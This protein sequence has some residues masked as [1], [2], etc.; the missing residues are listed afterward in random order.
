MTLPGI[1]RRAV[2]AINRLWATLESDKRT[3]YIPSVSL[4]FNTR[5]DELPFIPC[6]GG[7]LLASVPAEYIVEAHGLKVAFNLND[8]TRPKYQDYVLDFIEGQFI[9]LEKSAA[10]FIDVNQ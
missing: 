3:D 2:D 7:H 10:K 5:S 1:T 6:I 8:E 9:F 4:T